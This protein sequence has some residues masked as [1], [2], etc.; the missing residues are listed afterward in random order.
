V[1]VEAMADSYIEH[2]QSLDASHSQPAAI[3][4]DDF[5]HFS[6]FNLCHYGLLA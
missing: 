2:G 6:K 3:K 1:F 5:F 4:K